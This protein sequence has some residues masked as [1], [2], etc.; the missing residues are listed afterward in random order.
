[1]RILVRIFGSFRK[2]QIYLMF[3]QGI[4]STV[5]TF[6]HCFNKHRNKMKHMIF[7]WSVLSNS[8]VFAWIFFYTEQ[9]YWNV[10]WTIIFHKTMKKNCFWHESESLINYINNEG[11]YRTGLCWLYSKSLSYFSLS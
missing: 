7:L 4:M 3:L 1:M 2:C 6:Y 5:H 8:S 11:Y 9:R 10:I